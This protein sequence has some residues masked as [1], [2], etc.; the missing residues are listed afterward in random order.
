MSELVRYSIQNGIA[1]I[2][3]DDGKNN[4]L[5]PAMLQQINQALDKAEKDGAVTVLTGAGQVFSAGFDLKVMRTGMSSA[6]GMLIGGFRLSERLL[7]F[8]RPVVIACNG[9]AVAMGSFL[10]L[11][12][13]HRIGTAGDFRIA[14][15][16]VEIGLTMPHS[17]VEICKQRLNTAYLSRVV[18]LSESFN[19]DTAMLAGFLDEVVDAEDLA[20]RANQIATRLTNLDLAAHHA[21]KLRLRRKALKG[22]SRGIR[23]DKLDFIRMGITRAFAGNKKGT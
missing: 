7:S 20:A 17:A 3:L 8:P 15:N 4:L 9:H 2:T 11:S 21:T 10:L 12:A 16:E 13:D 18:N 6:F 5:S 1:T 22:L 14:A 19:P 23:A